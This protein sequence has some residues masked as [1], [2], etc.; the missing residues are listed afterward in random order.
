MLILAELLRSEVAAH[1]R[2]AVLVEAI[3][4]VLAGHADHA[5]FPVLK[6]A[7]VDVVSLLHWI[8]IVVDLY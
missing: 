4:E 5:P 3:S 7:F 8:S 1:H 2:V 6:I